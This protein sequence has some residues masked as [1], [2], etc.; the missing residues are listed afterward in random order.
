[1]PGLSAELAQGPFRLAL[2]LALIRNGYRFKKRCWLANKIGSTSGKCARS[3]RPRGN[4]R[5]RPEPHRLIFVEEA[6]D[7]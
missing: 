7:V 5:K 4:L 3:R 6:K 2:V 1:M